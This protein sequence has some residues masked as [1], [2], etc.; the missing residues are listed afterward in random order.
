MLKELQCR[1]FERRL[2]DRSEARTRR[3]Q[4][5]E[6]MVNGAAVDPQ[7]IES[8]DRLRERARLLAN[9]VPAG[10]APRPSSRV[11]L[12]AVVGVDDRLPRSFL[13]LG[14]QRSGAVCRMVGIDLDLQPSYGTGF[15]IGPGWLLTNNHVVP[16]A[17]IARLARAE[18]GYW[19]ASAANS[20]VRVSLDPD[21]GFVTSVA[22][23]YTLVALEAKVA[24]PLHEHFGSIELLPASG[25]ALIGEAV[26]II[27]H[28][29]AAPQMVSIR[30]NTVVDV[31]DHWMHYTT[32]TTPGSSGAPVL[33]DQWQLAAL[34]HASTTHT[35][36]T[37][38]QVVLNE[39]VRISSI[40][41]DLRS[42]L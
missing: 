5:V 27:S 19:T 23:D 10:A 20:T 33:N 21:R 29:D 28:G 40:V 37:G 41:A 6:A 26:N 11:V 38:R 18:F 7:R 4:A 8:A 9:E 31:F 17:Q 25:K 14:L 39:G 2:D 32:D 1:G 42:Q 36:S 15:C 24:E 34:H 16:T 13:D 3:L 35:T 12:E 30:E 22:L